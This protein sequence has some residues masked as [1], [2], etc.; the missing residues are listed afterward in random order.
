MKE[1][2]ISSLWASPSLFLYA[3][4]YVHIFA[5]GR[6]ARTHHLTL[7][8]LIGGRRPHKGGKWDTFGFTCFAH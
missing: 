1:H 5:N 6:A 2:A 7:N 8:D 3:T 4:K